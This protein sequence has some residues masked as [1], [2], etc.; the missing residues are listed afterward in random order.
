MIRRLE[1][2]FRIVAISVISLVLLVLLLVVN[3]MNISSNIRHADDT[4][5]AMTSQEHSENYKYKD[6]DDKPPSDILSDDNKDKRESYREVNRSFDVILDSDF[7]LLETNAPGKNII[8]R[9]TAYDLA[10]KVVDNN[11]TSGFIKGFRYLKID[12]DQNIKIAFLDYSFERRLELNLLIQSSLIYIGSIGLVTI[13]VSVFLRPVMKPIKESYAKQKQF[14]TDAS[15]ELKTPLTIISTDMELIKMEHGES[16]WTDSVDNQVKRLNSLTNELVSLSRMN[17]EDIKPEMKDVDL[18]SIVSDVVMGFEPAIEA[19]GKTIDIDIKENVHVIGNYD[20]LERVISIIM[21][22]ALKHS[23]EN[24]HIYVKL[25]HDKK[26]QLIFRNTVNNI[27]AGSH[28]EFFERFYRGDVSRNS[29]LGGFGIGLSIA[30]SII[31]EH[32]G[33]VEAMS[34]DATSLDIVITLKS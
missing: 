22:N 6:H 30:K 28:E 20:A 24:G 19:R 16:E 29:R 17:E 32:R 34:H 33:K 23:N 10:M 3:I 15:H 13:L 12:Q 14:I 26:T 27:E 18:S 9:D 1:K 4:L 7:N 11:S 8:N 21:N 31:E 5:K 2:R 25:S